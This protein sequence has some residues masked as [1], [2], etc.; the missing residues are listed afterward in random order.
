MK[1]E[2]S[3]SLQIR[4]K[5]SRSGQFVKDFSVQ[6]GRSFSFFAVAP[7]DRGYGH[8]RSAGAFAVVK[9]QKRKRAL[10]RRNARQPANEHRR[11]L[12]AAACCD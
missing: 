11:V 5:E 9:R 3:Q 2:R 4:S 12:G 7:N 8:W 6:H 10:N 1:S